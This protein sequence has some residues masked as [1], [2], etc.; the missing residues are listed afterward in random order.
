M[1]MFSY[2]SDGSPLVTVTLSTSSSL[3]STRPMF[4][5]VSLLAVAV[6]SIISPLPVARISGKFSLG[7]LVSEPRLILLSPIRASPWVIYIVLAPRAGSLDTPREYS[8]VWPANMTFTLPASAISGIYLRVRSSSYGWC[9]VRMRK[10]AFFA[11]G[12][13]RSS[14]IQFSESSTSLRVA[15]STSPPED[16]LSSN[17]AHG[18]LSTIVICRPPT[19]KETLRPFSFEWY[20]SF[21]VLEIYSSKYTP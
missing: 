2:L 8:W 16:E 10:S 21:W 1:E 18:L 20:C 14:L 6:H 5:Q 9:M 17:S 11:S 13:A 3:P 12:D 19:L 4:E 7:R 15:G